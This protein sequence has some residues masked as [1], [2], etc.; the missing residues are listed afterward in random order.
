MTYLVI[1]RP[2]RIAPP[3]VP[4]GEI[5]LV[6]PPSPTR[7][8]PGAVSW[9]Q[10]AF[11]VMGSG[12]ALLFALLNPRPLF[13][14]S[15]GLFAIGSVGMGVGMYVQQRSGRRGKTADDRRRYLEYLARVR[16][17][18]RETARAQ[19]LAAAWRHPPPLDLW[20]IATT[21]ERVW[22][23]R[24]GDDDFLE[25]RIG[26]GLRPLATPPVMELDEGP[27]TEYEPVTAAAARRLV[28][29]HGTVAE[30]PVTV[31][32]GELGVLSVVGERT[33][34]RALARALVCQLATFH[35]PD[36]LR[37]AFCFPDE[38]AGHWEWVKWLP[39]ARHPRS[40]DGPDPA[41]MA[42]GAPDELARQLRPELEARRASSRPHPG[43]E[44]PG[45]PS[46]PHLLVLVDTPV[47]LTQEQ[48]VSLR[49]LTAEPG[50]LGVTVAVLVDAQRDEPPRVDLRARVGPAS[51]RLEPATGDAS[52]QASSGRPDLVGP[53]LSEALARRLAPLRLSADDTPEKVLTD[54]IGLPELLGIGD[55]AELD[56][57]ATWRP[58]LG[59]EFLRVPIGVTAQG[60]PLTL[61]LKESAL[62]G[63]GPHGLMVGATGSGKSELLRT[64][65]TALAVTHPP[66]LLAFVLVD[67][68]G[69][70]TFAGMS[71]LPHVA[72]TIT[73]LQDDLAM[74]DR[75]HAALFGEQRRRQE[76]LRAA[77]NLASIREYH[78]RLAAGEEL[79]PLPFLLVIVDEFSELL[80]S[81]PE[82]IDLFV[83][84]GR[85]GRSLGMH[86]LFASQRLDEGRL[87]GLESHLSYRVGLRT[88]SA[89]ESRA[90]LG[91]PD[92]HELPAIPGSAYLKVDPD[93]LERFKAAMVSDPYRRPAPEH[94]PRVAVVA[95]FQVR[96]QATSHEQGR[97]FGTGDPSSGGPRAASVMDVVVSRLARAAPRVHQVW[98]PPLEP[99][100]PL[101]RLLPLVE[102]GD[103]SGLLAPGWSPGSRLVV[104]LGVVDRPEDQAQELLLADFTGATGHLAVVGSP[105]SG[106]STLLRTLLASLMLTHTPEEVQFY[107]VDL[108]GGTLQALAGAPHVGTVT[109]RHD[110][111]RARR[112]I[113]TVRALL[114]DREQLFLAR[115][116]D[117]VQSFRALR[118]AGQ[119]GGEE[120]GDVFLVLD[121]WAAVRQEFEDLEPVVVDLAA[122][123]LGYGIHLVLTANRWLD[124]RPNL[125][126]SI[127]GRLELRLVDPLDSEVGRREAAN[128][129]AGAPGRGLTLER[130]HFQAALPRIDGQA[131]A[132]GLQE[133][134]Q[135][136]VG[137][138]KAA[139]HGPA[140]RPVHVLPARLRHDELPAPGE[141]PEPGV[142]IGVAETD[143]APV[144]LDLQGPD[145][146]LAVFG[147]GQS[148]KTTLL[149]WFLHAL[150]AR[151]R[152]SQ[153]KILVV[154]YR[155]TLLEAVGPEHL[156]GYAGA[157]PAAEA[158]VAELREVLER[159]LPGPDLTVRQLRERSWWT[160]PEVYVV[161]DDYD[162]VVSPSGNP[163]L[164]LLDFLAQG[165]DVGVHLVL[166]RRVGG[167]ARA[168]YEP[169]LQRVKELGS[170]GIILSGDPDEGPLLGPYRAMPRVPGRGLLVRRQHRSVL[171][172]TPWLP[173]DTEV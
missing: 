87:R 104:P 81:R 167:A 158:M 20:T 161:V 73:N 78:Q 143:L 17:G 145:P 105:Q 44:A 18:L 112:A 101:N 33:A 141:D 97:A 39:H 119:L 75:M 21:P 172:Q 96:N 156:A 70:A 29:R 93:I 48:A 79:E 80:S 159:R 41:R 83:A 40:D 160:G 111:E 27:M 31:S 103:R 137:Y 63:M 23:R 173:L 92:A 116:I 164:P 109:G 24:R 100:I 7:S 90:V 45:A 3:P 49:E 171:L 19:R 144:Y 89:A 117:S 130:L 88:F 115:G 12:G 4:H 76:L 37:M 38:A 153:A 47:G 11:P 42:Y 123:G 163:L 56:P 131:S 121:N 50:R 147:D 64:L 165:R 54:S 120:L 124:I 150:T 16:A 157:A 30:Q 151:Q 140:V 43:Q 108:G 5:T 128:V 8:A 35:S 134:L 32:L 169:V 28:E 162:L 125:R 55:V 107:C 133:A 59:H 65:V 142:P 74:V 25:A 57:R 53:M 72:G 138:V 67:F 146:H 91:V 58:R 84:I 14:I 98:L 110:P 66:E 71:E 9:L 149:R 86:L 13:V 46:G 129:P 22:E 135:D 154:D 148:G 139:W 99:A 82:F 102:P 127:G 168:L 6:P 113:D 85:L 60:K 69:G 94:R 15:S 152:P 122:R 52:A 10:Y 68:K 118:A 36:D 77:G 51:I 62:G 114:D 26:L 132:T 61:D 170:P 126:D 34:A 136:L 155:R 106:K 1:H 2:A 166:A 95:P